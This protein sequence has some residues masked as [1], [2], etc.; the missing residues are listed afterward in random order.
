MKLLSKLL[1][2]FVLGIVVIFCGNLQADA[3]ENKDVEDEQNINEKL[4]EYGYPQRLIDELS[5][6]AKKGIIDEGVTEYAGAET[7]TYDL[8]YNVIAVDDYTSLEPQITPYGQINSMKVTQTA[9][10]QVVPSFRDEFVLQAQYAWTISP[11]QRRTDLIGFAWDGNKFNAMPDTSKVLVGG[12]GLNGSVT[13]LSRNL[14]ASSF[15]G[16]GWAFPLPSSGTRPIAVAQ[17]RIQE[18]KDSLNGTSQ[19]HNLYTHTVSGS[20][21]IGLSLGVLS[22]SFSGSRANDQ[23]A[24]FMNFNH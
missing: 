14:Y 15:T 6:I 24:S 10:R 5:Y 21:S 23:R 22:V 11:V 7:V 2:V 17:I 1:F 16:V 8:N 4:L 9:G 13:Y 3:S 19:F 20:G 12:N 18:K